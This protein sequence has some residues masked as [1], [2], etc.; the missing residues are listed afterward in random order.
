M[1]TF[2][3]IQMRRHRKGEWFA[4]GSQRRQVPVLDIKPS[5]S[6]HSETLTVWLAWMGHF[7]AL[8]TNSLIGKLPRWMFSFQLNFLS[9]S[10]CKIWRLTLEHSSTS[11]AT[12]LH[13]FKSCSQ[14][15]VSARVTE[16][17]TSKL[18]KNKHTHR[19]FLC[20]QLY[21]MVTMW[22]NMYVNY[23]HLLFPQHLYISKHPS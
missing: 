3:T 4:W 20:S 13:S 19:D 11:V 23:L 16:G 5:S 14:N 1:C 8:P 18:L 17:Y 9:K 7:L 21:K 22:G 6:V 15:H 10:P 12:A 2:P